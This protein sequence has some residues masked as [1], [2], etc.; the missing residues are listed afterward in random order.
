[1]IYFG[2]WNMRSDMHGNAVVS[3]A[4]MNSTITS[5]FCHQESNLSEKGMSF[6]VYPRSWDKWDVEQSNN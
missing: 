2:Q 4:V 3:G 5:S 6:S 1:M